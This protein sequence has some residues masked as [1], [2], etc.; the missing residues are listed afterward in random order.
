MDV[1]IIVTILFYMLSAAGYFAFLFLQ[2]NYLHRAGYLL[3]LAGFICHT[4]AIVYNGITSGYFPVRNLHETL[5]IAGWTV[6][7]FFLV[8]QSK[9]NL[10]V[11]GIY[12][13]PLVAL[14]M[15]AVAQVP[16][17][18]TEEQSIFNN[19]WLI[20]HVVTIFI[21]N[22]AFALACG[23]GI[24]YLLQE[25]AIKTKNPGFFF[26]RLPSLD[27][28]DG[29]AYTC[30]IVGFTLLTF[31]L[32][33]GFIYAKSIWGRFWSWDPKEVWSGI[34]WIFYAAMLHVR[35]SIG[36]RGRR[37]AIMAIIGFAI[38]LFTFLG[39]NFWLKGHHNPFTAF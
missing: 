28:L 27:M 5:A 19:F 10:K 2:K 17:T 4:L 34:T 9:F 8:F 6:A 36:W 25:R 38:L 11:L 3:V 20:S 39:V 22:A 14:I 30:I 21:G 32:I 1:L 37:A 18:P 26:R 23:I 13:A 31:G 12:A 24:L 16:N 35:L 33:S 7:G 15:I 29:T